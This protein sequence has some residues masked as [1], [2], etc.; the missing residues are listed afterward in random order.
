MLP[1]RGRRVDCSGIRRKLLNIDIV[2]EMWS[3]MCVWLTLLRI[4]KLNATGRRPETS[5]L[6]ALDIDYPGADGLF[7]LRPVK[8]AGYTG[9]TGDNTID[10]VGFDAQILDGDTIQFYFVNARPPVGAFNN[11]IDASKVG[12]N[13]TIEI[14]EMRRGEDQM[15]H[16]RTIWSPAV[17][18][19]NR[20][21]AVGGGA[22][23]VTNDHSVTVGLVSH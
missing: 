8:P 7:N 16:L 1:V 19:P 11:I 6:I 4:S 12:A 15:R 2:V 5:G 22:F 18:A 3:R 9:A 21:A 14:F 23:F 17:W 13:F 10:F 20:I